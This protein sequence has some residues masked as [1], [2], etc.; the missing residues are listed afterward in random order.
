MTFLDRRL[1]GVSPG[2]KRERGLRI[3]RQA[4]R[5]V[6]G[7]GVPLEVLRDASDDELAALAEAARE[8]NALASRLRRRQENPQ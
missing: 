5:R 7:V 8:R 2:H 3:L 4:L 6:G 1:E